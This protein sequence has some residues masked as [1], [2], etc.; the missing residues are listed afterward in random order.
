MPGSSDFSALSILSVFSVDRGF[1]SAPE[2]GARAPAGLSAARPRDCGHWTP[3]LRLQVI[4]RFA[5]SRKMPGVSIS[6]AKVPC[7]ATRPS[8]S[9]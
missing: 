8:S 9:T 2:R 6:S 5:R 3:R 7:C 4:W 1:P